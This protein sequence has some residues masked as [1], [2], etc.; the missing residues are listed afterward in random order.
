MV[1][2]SA[3]RAGSIVWSYRLRDRGLYVPLK[4]VLHLHLQAPPLVCLQWWPMVASSFMW[5]TRTDSVV[6]QALEYS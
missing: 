3:G 2:A 5:Y 4:R 1:G 6:E